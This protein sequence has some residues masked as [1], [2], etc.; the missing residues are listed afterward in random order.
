MTE[1]K[2]PAGIIGG[3]ALKTTWQTP[4]YLLDPVRAYFGGQI[5]LDVATAPNN[6]TRARQ[7]YCPTDAVNEAAQVALFDDELVGERTGHDALELPWSPA[8]YCNPPYGKALKER[9]LPRA[10]SQAREGAEG[11]LLLSCARWEQECLHELMAEAN[12][13]C[14][15]GKRVGK[16]HGRV[17]FINPETGDAVKGNTYANM[18]LAFNVDF[19]RFAEAF[20]KV[21]WCYRL[22]AA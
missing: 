10:A 19:E 7:F 9:W 20:G 3:R 18:F 2:A 1:P 13:V 14:W 15:I 4:E 11:F 12:A 8:F 5:P 6:P 17:D 16:H 22:G 21:G